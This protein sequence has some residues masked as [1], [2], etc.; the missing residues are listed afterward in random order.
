MLKLFL[1]AER[2]YSVEIWIYT[3]DLE[4]GSSGGSDEKNLCTKQEIW[5]QCLGWGDPL[6]KWMATHSIV[7]PGESHEQRSLVSDSP[8][9]CK[10]SDMN[11]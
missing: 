8:W 4:Q 9:D 11:E 10:E 6:E 5:V 1:D 3:N 2:E 7:L